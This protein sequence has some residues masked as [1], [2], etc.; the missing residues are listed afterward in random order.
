[1]DVILL[2]DVDKVGL[3]GEVVN[4][5]RGFMRNYLEPRRLAEWATLAKVAELEK[6]EIVRARHEACTFE[7]AQEIADTLGKT[8]LHFD[9]NA[10]PQGTLFGSVTPTDIADEWNSKKI[11]VDRRKIEPR[12]A[13]QAHRALHDPDR[14]LPGRHRR[15]PH[16]RRARGRRAAARGGARRDG[17]RGTGGG[18][19]GRGAAAPRRR[20]GVER[21]APRGRGRGRPR[22][23][24]ARGPGRGRGQGRGR[25]RGRPPRSRNRS[26]SASAFHR[27]VHR[28]VGAVTRN[29]RSEHAFRPRVTARAVDSGHI[30]WGFHPAYLRT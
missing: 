1:M 23:L 24:G 3:R 2:R 18:R 25:G 19:G 28:D 15:S 16:A 22:D 4:V 21:G 20:R 29:P 13:D 27:A 12:R 11:R 26:R 6:R 14:D 30:G 8:E 17:G 5:S 7:Q 9:V 10:G